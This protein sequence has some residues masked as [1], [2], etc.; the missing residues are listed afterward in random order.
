L[1]RELPL[2]P[3]L[4][5]RYSMEASI[6]TNIIQIFTLLLDAVGI[7]AIITAS[8]IL[9]SRFTEFSTKIGFLAMLPAKVEALEKTV[10]RLESDLNNLWTAFRDNVAY[11]EKRREEDFER[12]GERIE[13]LLHR[14]ERR[15]SRNDTR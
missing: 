5:E 1:G 15:E 2:P 13:N 6:S 9:S 7:I 11:Q 3:H 10:G 12:E 4:T 8:W 14:L